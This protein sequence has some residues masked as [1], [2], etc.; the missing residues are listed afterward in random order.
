MHYI[1][2]TFEDGSVARWAVSG[3]ADID[4]ATAALEG[5]IGRPDTTTD[6]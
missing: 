5:V 2:I 4:R 3:D 1:E 6:A